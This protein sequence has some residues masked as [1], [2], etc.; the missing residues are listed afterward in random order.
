M[1]DIVKKVSIEVDANSAIRAHEA[2]KRAAVSSYDDTTKAIERQDRALKHQAEV[3]EKIDNLEKE[4]RHRITSGGKKN[5]MSLAGSG[6]MGMGGAIV[7]GLGL[8]VLTSV[9]GFVGGMIEEGKKYAKSMKDLDAVSLGLSKN[10]HGLGERIGMTDIELA[11]LTKSFVTITG[12]VVNGVQRSLRVGQYEKAF[13]VDKGL[14]LGMAGT[15]R[16][17]TGKYENDFARLLKSLDSSGTI[18]IKGRNFALLSEK[19]SQYIQLTTLQG[20]R[21]DR[22][23]GAMTAGLMG[24]FGMVGGSFADQRQAETIGKLDQSIAN[25]NN[26]FKKAF[27]MEAMANNLKQQGLGTSYVNIM[28]QMEKGVFGKG[29]LQSVFDLIEKQTPGVN[30]ES[31]RIAL[32]DYTGLSWSQTGKLVETL[33]DKE[34]SEKFF[35]AANKFSEAGDKG[36]DTTKISD[37]IM[38]DFGVDITKMATN[39]TSFTETLIAKLKDVLGVTGDHFI[40]DLAKAIDPVKMMEYASKFEKGVDWVVDL[41]FKIFVPAVKEFANAVEAIVSMFGKETK[42]QKHERELSDRR[43]LELRQLDKAGVNL[44]QFYKKTTG[45]FGLPQMDWDK[46][47]KR[48]SEIFGSYA[49]DKDFVYEKKLKEEYLKSNKK[50]DDKK[51]MEQMEKIS[52]N[53]SHYSIGK[54]APLPQDK[55]IQYEQ[56]RID[57]DDKTKKDGK[58]G[59]EHS[60][61]IKRG[62]GFILESSKNFGESIKS[63][64]DIILPKFSNMAENM[65]NASAEI[66][67]ALLTQKQSEKYQ[68]ASDTFKTATG[69]NLPKIDFSKTKDLREYGYKELSKF[70]WE[71][72][73]NQK[74]LEY[75]VSSEG[76]WDSS[77]K[78]QT[79]VTGIGQITIANWKRL[80]PAFIKKFGHIPIKGNSQDEIDMTL[81]YTKD[82]YGNLEK[83]VEFKKELHYNPYDQQWEHLWKGGGFTGLGDGNDIA[84]FVHKKEFVVNEEGTRKNRALLEVMNRGYKTGGYTGDGNDWGFGNRSFGTLPNVNTISGN[85]NSVNKKRNGFDW[86]DFISTIFKEV[87]IHGIGEGLET[88]GI[89]DAGAFLHYTGVGA[90]L[91]FLFDTKMA[92]EDD[93]NKFRNINGKD[94]LSDP[95]EAVNWLYNHENESFT[96][97][98]F[99][100]P[101]LVVGVLADDMRNADRMFIQKINRESALSSTYVHMDYGSLSG[102]R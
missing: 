44:D 52:D 2:Y 15:E 68:T 45:L 83:A 96:Q 23:S 64:K 94:Y 99:S 58:G 29:N 97:A 60:E 98:K 72:E 86:T 42:E 1:A 65:S 6:I 49:T 71:G 27:T 70:G 17:T 101:K 79:G 37:Q 13:G 92:G 57:K 20:R 48:Y 11:K 12:D 85:K 16:M 67:A 93:V 77:I 75:I 10:L 63:F 4:R 91:S 66:N 82:R 74:R 38:K 87:G 55:I 59:G 102:V 89:E 51:A 19:I 28:E 35:A 30:T 39:N 31:G 50:K 73:E 95:D 69:K 84:G 26:D 100:N 61:N 18:D 54:Y 80:T 90:A 88:V 7:G 78:S 24:A 9:F 25:P 3:T 22:P 21:L 14:M 33:G 76:G 81:L 40:T 62:A 36:E 43:T 56:E 8:G 46:E 5:V 32:K 41:G 34:K 53:V 47:H